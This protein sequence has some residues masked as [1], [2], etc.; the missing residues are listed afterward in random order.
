M[1]MYARTKR[2]TRRQPS[3]NGCDREVAAYDRRER[4][5]M[6]EN[7]ES[8]IEDPL[9]RLC[10]GVQAYICE[11]RQRGASRRDSPLLG[12]IEYKLHSYLQVHSATTTTVV[13]GY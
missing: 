1:T 3:H 13:T 9:L 10:V 6:Q 5:E 7:F 12:D 11:L 2:Q 8:Q 4:Q